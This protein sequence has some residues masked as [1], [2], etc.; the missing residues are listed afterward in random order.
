MALTNAT[1]PRKGMLELDYE[2]F[3][4]NNIDKTG[5]TDVSKE[6]EQLL[7]RLASQGKTVKQNDGVYYINSNIV[8]TLL[9]NF[10]LRGC[11]FLPGA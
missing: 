8:M 2:T 1:K 10:D 7:I 4:E 5:T 9:D 3:D 11:T 6:I